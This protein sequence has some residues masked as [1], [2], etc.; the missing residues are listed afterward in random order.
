MERATRE[1]ATSPMIA[2]VRPSSEPSA[3]RRVSASASAW[4]GWACVPSPAFTIRRPVARAT[5]Y[6]APDAAWRSTTAVTPVRS[7]VRSVSTSDSPFA[8]L[9]PAI[10]RSTTVAPSALAASSKLTRVRVEAS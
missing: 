5:R 6:G 10:P 9:L 2:T 4:V 7:S 1:C 8:T 3:S